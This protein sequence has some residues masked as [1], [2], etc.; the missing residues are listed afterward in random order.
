MQY[1]EGEKKKVMKRQIR[2]REMGEKNIPLIARN[3][4]MDNVRK[5]Q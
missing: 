4:R 3:N 2:W 5:K 1:R